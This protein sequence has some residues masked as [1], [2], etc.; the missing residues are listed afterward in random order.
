MVYE[1]VDLITQ[2]AKQ[3]LSLLQNQSG[4]TSVLIKLVP[5]R[6]ASSRTNGRFTIY[7]STLGGLKVMVR[8][9]SSLWSIGLGLRIVSRRARMIS[10][11]DGKVKKS[12]KSDLRTV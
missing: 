2:D 10:P 3:S 12:C 5:W 1:S 4:D 6:P 9:I 8:R 7:A 11:L